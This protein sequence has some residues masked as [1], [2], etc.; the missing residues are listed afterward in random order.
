MSA[1]VIQ[2]IETDFELRGATPVE[3]LAGHVARRVTQYWSLDGRLL[4]EI[5]PAPPVGTS[6]EAEG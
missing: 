6:E 5:D 2:V 3:Q 1:R 4:W